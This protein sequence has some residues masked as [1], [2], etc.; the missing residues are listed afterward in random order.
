MKN[1][2]YRK[3]LKRCIDIIFSLIGLIFFS[4][5]LVIVAIL[6]RINLGAPILF[7]QLRPGKDEK[8]F[9]LYKFRTMKDSYDNEGNLLPDE[10]RLTKFGRFLR[11]T[12]LD[13]LPELI[14][15]L[16]GE[17]SFIGPRPLLVEYLEYYTDEEKVRH[18]VLPGL[19]GWAQINGRNVTPWDERL[20]QDIYYV[21]NINLILDLKI[22]FLTVIKVLKK[23]DIRVGKEHGETSRR[24]DN[25]RKN[26]KNKRV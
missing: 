23:S 11:K 8:V 6:V 19:T 14:N 5:L 24:L 20:K 17:M 18:T 3:Y 4:W 7:K 15:I 26:N 25:V 1:I 2:F 22:L 21:N 12:S 13:E 10:E 16:K 9:S